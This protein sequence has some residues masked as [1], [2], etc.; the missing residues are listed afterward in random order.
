MEEDNPFHSFFAESFVN[1]ESI[2]NFAAQFSR[3]IFLTNNFL[4]KKK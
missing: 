3:E 2:C 1:K 4:I